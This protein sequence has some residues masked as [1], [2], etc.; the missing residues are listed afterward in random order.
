MVILDPGDERIQHVGAKGGVDIG[1]VDMR[2][3]SPVALPEDQAR[4]LA[5]NGISWNGND[6]ASPDR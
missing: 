5:E 1:A 4:W 3:S 6:A 2:P